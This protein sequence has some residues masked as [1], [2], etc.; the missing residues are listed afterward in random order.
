MNSNARARLQELKDRL[1]EIS[2]INAAAALLSWDQMTLMPGV[3]PM[4]VAVN[5]RLWNVCLTKS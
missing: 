1:V 5:W 4:P 3:E 2:D